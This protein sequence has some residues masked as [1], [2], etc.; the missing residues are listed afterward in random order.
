MGPVDNKGDSHFEAVYHQLMET[1]LVQIV[2][3]GTGT[4][5]LATQVGFLLLKQMNLQNP[6]EKGV[7]GA[8]LLMRG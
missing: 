4:V 2:S 5:V 1:S 7:P 8:G 6:V 3:P